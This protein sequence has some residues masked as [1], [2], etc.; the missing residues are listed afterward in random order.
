MTTIVIDFANKVVYAD[1]RSTWTQWNKT[2]LTDNKNQQWEGLSDKTSKIKHGEFDCGKPFVIV[3]AGDSN[4]I[5]QFE[6]TY[7]DR[8]P[9]PKEV[10]QAVIFVIAEQGHGLR[11][12]EYTPA[13]KTWWSKTCWEYTTYIKSQG[14]LTAGSGGDYAY[15]ALMAGVSPDKVFDAVALCDKGTSSEFDKYTFGGNQ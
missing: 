1:K 8:V 13:K 4:L 15:G 5:S 10:G 2:F 14:F 11:V 7:P 6:C 9:D 3:G 12:T